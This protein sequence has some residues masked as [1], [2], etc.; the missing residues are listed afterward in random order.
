VQPEKAWTQLSNHK[1]AAEALLA[2]TAPIIKLEQQITLF[3]PL[4]PE[5]MI[6]P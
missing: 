2:L 1:V 4:R 3:G 6:R 5:H